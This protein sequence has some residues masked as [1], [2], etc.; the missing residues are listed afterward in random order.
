MVIRNTY[1]NHGGVTHRL[2]AK[3]KKKLK[4]IRKKRVS[5]TYSTDREKEVSK[6]F[7]I[8]LRLIVP[9][10]KAQLSNLAGRTV[11]YGPQN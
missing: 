2:Q 1:L 10:G 3:A 11:Q 9:A 8:R 4:S 5:V 6:I 7:I